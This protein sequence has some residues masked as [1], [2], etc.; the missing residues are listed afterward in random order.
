MGREANRYCRPALSAVLC[1]K[2]AEKPEATSA[3]IEIPIAI[4]GEGTLVFIFFRFS[5]CLSWYRGSEGDVET[6]GWAIFFH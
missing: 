1:E 3:K 2:N 6:S 5:A 4:H